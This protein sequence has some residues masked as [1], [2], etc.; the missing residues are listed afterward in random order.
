VAKKYKLKLNQRQIRFLF[1]LLNK[2]EYNSFKPLK[3]AYL[4]CIKDLTKEMQDEL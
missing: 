1:L 3:K 4:K 2:S